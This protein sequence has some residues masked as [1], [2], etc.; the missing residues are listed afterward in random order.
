M[1]SDSSVKDDQIREKPKIVPLPNG[2]YVL[3]NDTEPKIIENLQNSK[4]EH[5]SS[6]PGV[7]L[8][9]CGA[10]NNKPFCDGTHSKIGFSS[11]NKEE[12]A[13]ANDHHIAK[14]KRKNFVGKEITIHDNRKICSHAAECV[15]NLPSVFKLNARPWIS[16]DAAER[17]EI[18]N[19]IRKCPSGA[20]SYSLDGI[21]YRDQNERKPMITVSKDGPYHVTGGI[22]L[23]GEDNNNIQWAEGSSKEHYV[24]CRCG[25]SNNK[26]FCDGMHRLINF[27]DDKD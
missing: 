23:I 13:N 25:A 4:G 21:E 24:L 22:N 8:C 11:E 12:D 3:I 6:I 18:I 15:N 1:P 26:P 20:L 5:L 17:E 16:P 10:S 9:R 19:T 2:P 14:D 7:S 27:K